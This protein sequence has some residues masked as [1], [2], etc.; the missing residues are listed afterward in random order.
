VVEYLRGE[1]ID[2]PFSLFDTI[3]ECL[4]ETDRFAITILPQ[5]VQAIQLLLTVCE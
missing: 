5:S 4:R 1:E 3:P 2:E